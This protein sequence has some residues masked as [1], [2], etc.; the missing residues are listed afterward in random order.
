MKKY[1]LPILLIS[2]LHSYSQEKKTAETLPNKTIDSIRTIKLQEVKVLTTKDDKVTILPD[3]LVYNLKN[4]SRVTGNNV[5]DVLRKVPLIEADANGSLKLFGFQSIVVYV[6]GR[7]SNLSGSDLNNYLK[8]MPADNIKTV[9]VIFNPSS[10]Y[11]SAAS[12]GIVL[13]TL[14]R[15][16]D[17][18]AKG[19]VTIT[20][21]QR[22]RNSP[23]ISGFLNYHKSKFSDNFTINAGNTVMKPFET[24]QNSYDNTA[25]EVISS[26]HLNK[27][28]LFGFS[29]SGDYSL[30]E[31]NALGVALTYN[32]NDISERATSINT[33]QIDDATSGNTY[34]SVNN[35]SSTLN[36]WNAV[37]F[38]KME[39]EAS[40]KSLDIS[41][42]YNYLTNK[43]AQTFGSD[44][45]AFTLLNA[46]DQKITIHTVKVDYAQ[47]LGK[48]FNLQTGA[49]FN[50]TFISS[51]QRIDTLVQS[52]S[53]N[54][55]SEDSFS[56]RE[57]IS[58]AYFS[59]DKLFFKRLNITAGTRME[60]SSI[61]TNSLQNS[62]YSDYLNLFPSLSATFMAN[63]KNAF[64]FSL[65]KS[66]VRP[67]YSQLNPFIFK[68]SDNY[69]YSGNNNLGRENWLLLSLNY[70]YNRKQMFFL[71]YMSISNM[72]FDTQENLGGNVVVNKP[73]NAYGTLSVT[74]LG[75]TLKAQVLHSNLSIRLT[76][77]LIYLNN[78]GLGN[79]NIQR[80]KSSFLYKGSLDL[81]SSNVFNSNI[82]VTF[83]TSYRTR[84]NS[85][86]IAER[87]LM[88][89]SLDFGRKLGDNDWKIA[90]NLG[91][92]FL[93]SVNSNI[94]YSESGIFGTRSLTDNKSFRISVSKSFGNSKS[95][96]AKDVIE[97]DSRRD[98]KKNGVF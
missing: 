12:S 39:D 80:L 85:G 89:N 9:E 48:G 75:N 25:R 56:Y 45:A 14:N 26:S 30:N 52:V 3:R 31:K 77:N 53:Q 7:K 23:T 68:T 67:S 4:T 63:K 16:E 1:I 78:D 82:D 33:F 41:Y 64:T 74:M 15:L 17:D 69:Y 32:Y 43:T 38:Y 88:M 94:K 50:H 71:R 70:I 27:N 73:V 60:Y 10:K 97:S 66:V 46:V 54:S 21:E 36:S 24:Y 55:G 76:N 8:N 5:W 91:N 29:N 57:D 49:K 72:I 20:D 83:W 51:P 28:R 11:E 86:N 2:T 93:S 37:V 61:T 92:L 87:G 84:Y 58:A 44:N 22:R 19:S 79:Q 13:I 59:L 18:G 42:N 34:N 40:K 65:N 98:T 6:N 96:D 62:K 95:K 47:P 81:S 35:T 90:V